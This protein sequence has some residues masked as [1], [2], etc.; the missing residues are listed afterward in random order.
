MSFFVRIVFFLFV[1]LIAPGSFAASVPVTAPDLSDRVPETCNEAFWDVLV[2]RAQQEAQREVVQ[3]E[4]LIARPDSVLSMSCFQSHMEHLSRRAEDHFPGD[5]DESEGGTLA[6]GGIFTDILVVLVRR[7]IG[8]ADPWAAGRFGLKGGQMNHI[9]EILVLDS[10]TDNVTTIGNLIDDLAALDF[11]GCQ[12]G[13]YIDTNLF[14]GPMLGGRA[15]PPT[16]TLV[17]RLPNNIDDNNNYNCAMMDQVWRMAKCT[18]FQMDQTGAVRQTDRFHRFSNTGGTGTSYE[19]AANANQDFRALPERCVNNSVGTTDL[20]C[21]YYPS[22]IPQ[23]TASGFLSILT[24]T[25]YIVPWTNRGGT[26]RLWGGNSLVT[27]TDPVVSWTTLNTAVNPV[28]S[29][30]GGGVDPYTH[31]RELFFPPNCSAITPV[32]TGV[33]VTDTAGNQYYDAVCPAPGCW[34]NPP[35]SL[36]ATGSCDPP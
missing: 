6:L 16:P 19:Q 30:A 5:P 32:R 14:A 15:A 8:S 17:G 28:P 31:N 1:V 3:N 33:I 23:V 21:A 29:I 11:L 34:Y 36:A 22:G 9:L 18:N 13:Y 24:G 2:A 12:K 25:G 20:I 26:Q 35:T 4:N 7:L 10:L 27:G